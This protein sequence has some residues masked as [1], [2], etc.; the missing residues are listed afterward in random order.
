MAFKG[1]FLVKPT[2]T[3]TDALAGLYLNGVKAIAD[4]KREIKKEE[5]GIL[6]EATEA[7]N[8]PVSGV[9]TISN[10]A[11]VNSSQAGRSLCIGPE[12][13]PFGPPL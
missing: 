8:M 7:T 12:I 5:L 6:K 13:P 11:P 10:L 1:G 9:S 4:K 3:S 2:T